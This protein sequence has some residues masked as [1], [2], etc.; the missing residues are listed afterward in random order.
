MSRSIRARPV[1]R[2]RAFAARGLAALLVATAAPAHAHGFGQRYDLPLPLSLY[3][4]ATAAAIVLSFVVTALFVRRAPASAAY[5]RLLVP[6]PLARAVA[7]PWPAGLLSLVSAILFV[8]AI[9]AG[10]WGN[11]DPYRNIAPTLIWI[12]GW[13]GLVYVSAFV[14]DLWTPINPWRTLYR[15]AQ[16]IAGRVSRARDSRPPLAYPEG[17]GVWPAFALLFVFSWTELVYPAPAVPRHIAWMML[18][19]S[20]ATFAGMAVFG[21]DTWLERGELFSVV[22]GIFARFAPT[23]SAIREGR[24]EIA[25]R[26]FASGLF[27]SPPASSSQTALVLLILASVLYD[28]ALGTPQWT[29]V[30]GRLVALFP[31]SDAAAAIIVRTLGLAAA[32]CLFY[33]A[34]RAICATMAAVAGERSGAALARGFAWTLV[35]IAAAYHLAHYLTYLL[36]QGQYI[37]ALVSDPFG[38]GWNLFGT[39]GYR[40]DIGVVGAR[41]A[42]YAAVVA[43]VVGHVIAVVLAHQRALRSFAA[44]GPALRSQVPLTALMVAYTFVSLSILAEPITERRVPEEEASANGIVV[45][46][47]AM[48]PDAG[49]GELRAVGPGKSAPQKLTYRVLGSAFHDGTRTSAADL[50]Y[51]FAFAYRWGAHGADAAHYDPVVAAATAS[52]REHLVGLKIVGTDTASKSFRVGDVDVVREMFIVDV[53]LDNAPD[54]PEQ[55][56]VI[57][58]PWSTVPWHVLALMEEAVVRGWAAFSKDEAARRG[59]EW[60]DLVRSERLKARLASLVESFEREGYRPAALRSLVTADDARKRWAALAAFYK[61][62]GHFLVT[63]GPYRLKGWSDDRVDLD[64]FRDLSYPLGVGSF[65]A[66]AIPRRGFVTKVEREAGGLRLSGEIET[67]MRF[68]RSYEIHRQALETIDPR[69]VTRAAPECRYTVIDGAGRVVLAGTAQPGDD[70]TFRLPLDAGLAP[71][72]YTVLAEIAVNGNAVNADIRRIPVQIAPR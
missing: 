21:R 41:F 55:D 47:D 28:G 62:H 13:V 12:I 19:Y 71:G 1:A 6:G 72:S 43:I 18:G 23:E 65:D 42:W 35:P 60:L 25:L 26:P 22:F 67:V 54:D 9:A 70:A 5:P 51:A 3:L 34:Y 63:N 64:V 4:W 30:E 53:Y 2:R 37:V 48:L 11:Q 33:G 57:A 46:A 40:V 7:G 14:G 56:A 36:V 68:Q 16:W 52:L 69:D 20:V 24:R 59:V 39:A 50:L 61:A 10:L 27:A 17:L 66:Y 38:A 49:S 44:H 29:A 31:G 8:T 45:A 58:P 32:W 15:A